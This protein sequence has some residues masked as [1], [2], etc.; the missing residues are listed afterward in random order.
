[1]IFEKNYKRKS[2]RIN[3]PIHAIIENIKYNVLDWSTTGM[4][5]ECISKDINI[6]DELD[7]SIL[8]PTQESAIVL[9][10]KA[11]VRNEYE[12]SYGMEFIDISDKNHRVLRHY[13]TFAI[14]GS[15]DHIDD[16][17]A[18]LFMTN[19]QTPM[20]EPV[21]LTDN[22][23][24][25]VHKIF[26]KKLLYYM[27]FAIVFIM[28]VFFTLSYN[29]IVIYKDNGIVSGNSQI[30][31]AP[32][33][34]KIKKIYIHQDQ[35]IFKNQLLFEMDT[36]N[37]EELLS[38]LLKRRKSL[39]KRLKKSQILLDKL[40]K[41]LSKKSI[42][43]KELIKKRESY[44]KREFG[45]ERDIF[46]RAKKLYKNRLITYLK[47]RD[48][49]SKYLEFISEYESSKENN[50]T[51]K[52]ILMIQQASLK[53]KDQTIS[54]QKSINSIDDNIQKSSFAILSLKQKIA[55]AIVL[56][57]ERG[58]VHDIMH[59]SGEEVK[60]TDDII[61]LET[62]NKPYILTK[63]SSKK[64]SNIHIGEESLLYYSKLGITISGKISALGNLTSTNIIQSTKDEILVK[65][66]IDT[67]DIDLRLG[68]YLKVY[69][70]NDSK[71]SKRILEFLPRG[72]IAR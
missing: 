69:F 57:K 68:E 47:Y 21:V 31:K 22:E 4:R 60:F 18:D 40:E 5:V 27:L 58:K 23:D 54:M 71:L 14:D 43:I 29:Y 63:I 7:L 1:M 2:H 64:V 17:S 44:L 45:I 42:K 26:L 15:L 59:N 37:D 48:I 34:G 35:E 9:R 55:S 70:L 30:Y 50:F 52:D 6:G 56:S 3:I 51:T 72:V 41:G 24:S 33:D 61:V 32:Y 36:K 62:S 28:F 25:E 8:L 46:N 67:R 10:V 65:I 53:I 49:E 39:L 12:D 11:I 19:V 13:A 66:E 38:N 16:L 20:K